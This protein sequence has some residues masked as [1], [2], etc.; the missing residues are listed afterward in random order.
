MFKPDGGQWVPLKSID[1]NWGGTAVLNA[2]PTNGS[3]WSLINPTNNSPMATDSTIFPQ[4]TDNATNHFTL[5]SE[6]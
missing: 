5:I 2:S 4:W 6:P 1:W 3:Y